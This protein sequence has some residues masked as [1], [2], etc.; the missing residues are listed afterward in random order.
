MKP[1]DIKI[2]PYILVWVEFFPNKGC[3]TIHDQKALGAF[4][5]WSK[6]KTYRKPFANKERAV[7]FLISFCKKLDKSYTCLIS[8]DKQYSMA[9]ESEGYKIP[10]TRKQLE[11]RYYIN[12]DPVV[13]VLSRIKH[14]GGFDNLCNWGRK[15]VAHYVMANY[16]RN[17]RIAWKVAALIM[18]GYHA[19]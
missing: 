16:C 13:N 3:V 18:Y 17:K 4:F 9:K 2:S 12:A 10:Y 19:K 15:E 6:M 7:S 5:P 8:T 11:N 14:E 1:I